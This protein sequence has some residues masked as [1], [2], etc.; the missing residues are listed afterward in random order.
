MLVVHMATMTLIDSAKHSYRRPCQHLYGR[1]QV[2]ERVPRFHPQQSP[3]HQRTRTVQQEEI[4]SHRDR[5]DQAGKFSGQMF[6]Q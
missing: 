2:Q 6:A 1:L 4:A 5:N 3:Y